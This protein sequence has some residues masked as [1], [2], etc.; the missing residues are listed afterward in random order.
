MMIGVLGNGH[1]MRAMVSVE[2]TSQWVCMHIYGLECKRQ[3]QVA[4]KNG[5]ASLLVS[6]YLLLLRL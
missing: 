4:N 2:L 6:W 1:L 5:K 3:W